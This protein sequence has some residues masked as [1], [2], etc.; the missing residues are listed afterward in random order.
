MIIDGAPQ[1]AKS[2]GLSVCAGGGGS[3]ADT[4]NIVR[5]GSTIAASSVLNVSLPLIGTIL[6]NTGGD[7]L[8][9]VGA[10]NDLSIV[11]YMSSNKNAVVQS[12]A[13]APTAPW[14]IQNFRVV[15][16]YIQI[17][18]NA[19][20][21]I[22]QETGGVFRWSTTL[23][24]GFNYTT[25]A[26]ATADAVIVP[27]KCSSAKT[28]FNT[29]RLTSGN[30]SYTSNV[31][32]QRSNPFS[33]MGSA[34]TSSYYVQIGAACYPPIPVRNASEHFIEFQKAWHQSSIPSSYDCNMAPGEY[35]V[36]SS[37]AGSFVTGLD[38]ESFTGKSGVAHSGVNIT[39]GTTAIINCNYEGTFGTAPAPGGA[40]YI[41]TFLNYDAIIEISG[42]QTLVS[43]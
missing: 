25:S 14:Q 18:E 24:R 27:F 31:Q 38:L 41:N 23:W 28:I 32:S 29:W 39:G 36:N 15:A 37:T 2:T 12:G 4:A 34:N 10:M 3:K 1:S 40:C 6:D 30:E 13:S 42:G 19:Q 35:D 9:P 26:T 16:S 8:I 33:P 17:D 7:K 22:D 21:M 11:I 5:K 43:Y 20:R